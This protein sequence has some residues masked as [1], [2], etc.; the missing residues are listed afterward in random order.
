[1]LAHFKDPPGVTPGSVM[2]PVK[3]DDSRI[4]DLVAFVMALTAENADVMAAPGFVVDGAVL[5]QQSNCGG[6]HM[7]NGVG[8]KIGPSLN[9]ISSRRTESWATEHFFNPEKLSPG[10]PMPSYRFSQPEVQN[11]VSYL[12]TLPDTPPAQ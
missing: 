11:I 8:G 4:R 1:M 6:C 9:G 2:T 10:T 12:F 5:Y 7:V 3:L